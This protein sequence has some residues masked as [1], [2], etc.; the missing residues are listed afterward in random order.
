VKP[1][2][3]GIDISAEQ[4]Q[5]EMYIYRKEHTGDWRTCVICTGGLASYVPAGARSYDKLPGGNLLT[6]CEKELQSNV[7]I[8]MPLQANI[9]FLPAAMIQISFHKMPIR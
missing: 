1:S 3:L 4:R 8:I 7:R 5:K 9:L 6:G 2:S